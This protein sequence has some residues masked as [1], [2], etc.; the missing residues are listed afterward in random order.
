[1]GLIIPTRLVYKLLKGRAYAY[2]LCTLSP[3]NGADFSE[4]LNNICLIKPGTLP[5]G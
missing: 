4:V 1:M 2:L 3:Y 5:E